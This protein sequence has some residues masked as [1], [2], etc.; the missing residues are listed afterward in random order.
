MRPLIIAGPCAAETREQ[1]L[2]TARLMADAGVSI[3]RAGVW[4][5]RTE[6]GAFEGVGEEALL[7]LD[8]AQTETGIPAATEVATPEHVRLALKHHIRTLWIGAR[9]TTN[10]FLV[11]Q[12]ADALA[13]EIKAKTVSP[14]ELTLLV[15]NP[16]SPDARLW[17]GA[18]ERLRESE[19]KTIYA[20]HRGFQTGQPTPYRNAP[21]WSVPFALRLEMPEIPLL[22]DPSH[23][24]GKTELVPDLSAQA[25]SLGYDG[26]MI[27]VHHSPS[28]AWSDR[29]QQLTPDELKTL[30]SNLV[31]REDK[32][33]TGLSNLRRQLD[34]TDDTLFMLILQRMQISKQIGVYK[35][36]HNL[37]VLQEKRYAK[38]LKNRLDWA[39]KNGLDDEVVQRI[40]EALHEES[41]RWQL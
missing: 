35:R 15:K 23:M 28:N 5:P 22:L 29:E 14:A 12:I 30:M 8:E 13:E 1:V 4:K 25:M 3:F 19:I 41:C 2:T 38:I 9:T 11:Q 40:M 6:P 32:T 26:L 24:A 39:R 17:K 33:D 31:L 34:E 27:E 21:T 37:P 16:V 20:V 10:P 7:W 18:I 36:E